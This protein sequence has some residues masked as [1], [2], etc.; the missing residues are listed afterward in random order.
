MLL[1]PKWEYSIVKKIREKFPNIQWFLSTH[2]P[3]LILG[4]S[5]DAVFY[6]LYKEQGK[7]KIS[8]E[9]TNED[10]KHLMAN[11]LIT[12]PLFDMPTARMKSLK[13]RTKMDTSKNYWIGQIDDKIKEQIETEKRNGK[14]YISKQ[15]IDE[16][17]T[18]AVNEVDKEVIND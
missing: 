17:V 18:W 4:A 3:M 7:T 5:E 14:E 10:I 9:W 6:R 16:F 8:E 2:S 13:D 12:S 1:H 11:S 15:Q